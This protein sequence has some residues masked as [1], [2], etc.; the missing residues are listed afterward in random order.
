MENGQGFVSELIYPMAPERRK[1][2]ESALKSTKIVVLQDRLVSSELW[3]IL[4]ITNDPFAQTEP[5]ESADEKLV[6]RRL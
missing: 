2:I 4:P 5:T 1:E 3:E 6:R